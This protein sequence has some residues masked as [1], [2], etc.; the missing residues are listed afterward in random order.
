MCAMF[1]DCD[2]FIMK[3]LCSFCSEIDWPISRYLRAIFRNRPRGHNF[4]K[5]TNWNFKILLFYSWKFQ[6]KQVI[7]ARNS[8]KQCYTHWKFY[9]LKKD[10]RKFHIL[11]SWSPLKI[12]YRFKLSPEKSSGYFFNTPG[13]SIKWKYDYIFF[14]H[15][16]MKKES[17]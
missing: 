8:T 7:T 5:T 2:L 9:G 1:K 13:N 14:R 12:P 11:L 4:L 16:K 10:P 6:T 15:R 17:K 3:L